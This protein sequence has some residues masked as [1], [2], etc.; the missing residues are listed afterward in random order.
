MIHS[1]SFTAQ[2]IIGK[3]SGVRGGLR[4]AAITGALFI[5]Q[6]AHAA[7]CPDTL[8]YTANRLQDDAPQNM[9]QYAGKV[10][11]VVNT[12]SFCGYT[13]QYKSLEALHT[14]LSGK[15][16]VV[17]GFPSNEFGAQEPGNN[18]QIAEFCQNT[19][20]VKFPMMAKTAV[21]GPAAHPFYKTLAKAT[22]QTPQWNFYK[23]LIDRDGKVLG[24]YPSSVSPDSGK[25]LADIESA[26]ARTPN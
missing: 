6:A 1:L 19:F 13:G 12:A 25:L 17:L 18:K 23:Y 2:P 4:L 15:G 7:N 22:G 16:L 11:L 3:L 5:G 10:V 8:N 24:A 9:C 26:L 21:T 14:K 20:G